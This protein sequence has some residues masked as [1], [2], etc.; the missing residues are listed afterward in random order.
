MIKKAFKFFLYLLLLLTLPT[1]ILYFTPYR[2]LI[3]GIS[4]T[5]LRGRTSA[6]IY[7]A[8][9]FDVNTISKNSISQPLPKS[10]SYNKTELS[11]ALNDMLS[12]TKSTSYMVIKDNK[13]ICEKY[14]LNHTDSTKSNSFSMAKTITTLLVQIAIQKKTIANW[15]VKVKNY[16]PWLSGKYADSLTLRHLSTMTAGLN[17]DEGYHNPFGITARA[18]FTDDIETTMKLVHVIDNPGKKYIYQS[19]ATQMLGLCLIQATGKSLAEYA[20]ENLWKPLK[21]E[22]SA[23]WHTDTK[24]GRELCYCC[25][26]AST[27]DFA[28]I[29]TLL[30]NNGM[31]I[32][33]SSF[34]AT[35]TQPFKDDLYGHSFWLYEYKNNK[36]FFLQG[37]QGQYIAVVPSKKMVIVRTGHSVYGGKGI[38][39]CLKTYVAES[40]DLFG[41][42]N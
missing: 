3:K 20:A 42:N 5:Y 2:Y 30:L 4:Q 12:K 19:G 9:Y 17:W 24:N 38:H 13:I 26:N 39:D 11:V 33:D 32:V 40:I 35:A 41:E 25:F 7:D 34:I 21:T 28:K 18:Y 6:Y 37:I 27:R 14:Y 29:G 1:T 36:V 16:L 23:S 10:A 31:G 8:Q 22:H 15:D